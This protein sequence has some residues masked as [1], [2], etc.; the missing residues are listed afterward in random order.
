MSLRALFPIYPL[1]LKT[2][3]KSRI[4]FGTRS[5]YVDFPWVASRFIQSMMSEAARAELTAEYVRE[6]WR[7]LVGEQKDKLT[8]Q[9]RALASVSLVSS[10]FSDRGFLVLKIHW[11]HFVDYLEDNATVLFASFVDAKSESGKILQVY[12]EIWMNFF[13][14]IGVLTGFEPSYNPAS[15]VDFRKLL[16]RTGDYD[17]IEQLLRQL[18]EVVGKMEPAPRP[19][20][21]SV[22]H[23]TTNL[24]M[25]VQH[26]RTAFNVVDIPACYL[27]LRNLLERIVELFILTDIGKSVGNIDAVLWSMFLHRYESESVGRSKVKLPLESFIDQT[28][29]KFGKILFDMQGEQ[30]DF[31]VLMD[32][33]SSIGMPALWINTELLQDFSRHYQLNEADLVRVYRACGVVIHNQSP[34]PFFSLLE[35]K[36]FKKFLEAYLESLAK[37]VQKLIGKEIP[38][39][40]PEISASSESESAKALKVARSLARHELHVKNAIAKAVAELSRKDPRSLEWI[41]INPMTLSSLFHLISANWTDLSYPTFVEDDIERI[42]Q[43]LQPHSFKLSV[44]N[45]VEKTLDRMEESLVTELEKFDVFSSLTSPDLKRKVVLYL[46]LLYLPKVVEDERK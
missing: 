35:V 44:Q 27:I 15:L 45:E 16:E 42:V 29:E 40:K 17:Y 38:V 4:K 24:R 26:I 9:G 2:P 8:R 11:N 30:L 46:L 18:E 5:I 34:L 3:A 7:K 10:P 41:W 37:V 22:Q 12:R 19:R 6:E 32:R 1:G 23:Y 14:A 13:N 25:N 43:Q 39:W 28:K 21:S 31:S 36:F 20:F 33:L